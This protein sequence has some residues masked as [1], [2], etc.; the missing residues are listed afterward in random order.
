MSRRTM[1]E[2]ARMTNCELTLVAFEAGTVIAAAERNCL[3]VPEEAK[4]VFVAAYRELLQRPTQS[5]V[6]ESSSARSRLSWSC[7]HAGFELTHPQFGKLGMMRDRRSPTGYRV[8]IPA[9][10]EL[11]SHSV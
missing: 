4:N 9:A 7:S 11:A 6:V 1:E 2:I 5:G 8:M 10:L 3:P